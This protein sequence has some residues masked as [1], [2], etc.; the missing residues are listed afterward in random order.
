VEPAEI[1]EVI[2]NCLWG[3]WRLSRATVP[4][5]L[6][7]GKADVKNEFAGLT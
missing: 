5:T 3:I 1:L 7:W 6:P 2:G 4:A